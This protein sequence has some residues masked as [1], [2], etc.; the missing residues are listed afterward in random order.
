MDYKRHKGAAGPVI[1]ADLCTPEGVALLWSWLQNEQVLAVFLAPPCGSASRA[2]QIP[3]KR[4]HFGHPSRRHHGPRPLRDDANPNGLPDLSD[5]DKQRVSLAN[6]LYFLTAQIVQWAVE[7]GVIICV[8]NPQFSLFL[9]HDLLATGC[10]SF[11]I[12]CFSFM[13]IWKFTSE[14]NDGCV[15]H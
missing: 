15:Q 12:F 2:R 13:P 3:L 10:T 9:G 4:K 7:N 11:G 6:Q 14:E 8:E 1:L 5:T